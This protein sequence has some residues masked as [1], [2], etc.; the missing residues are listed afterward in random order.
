MQALVDSNH[1][2]IIF[3]SVAVTWRLENYDDQHTINIQTNKHAGITQHI[4]THTHIENI[5]THSYNNEVYKEDLNLKHEH[6]IR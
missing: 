4:L 5:N 1:I 3:L 6:N 2:R